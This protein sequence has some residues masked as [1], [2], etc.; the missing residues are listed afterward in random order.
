MPD[1]TSVWTPLFH[2]AEGWPLALCDGSTV[3]NQGF[4]TIRKIR[5]GFEGDGV[6]PLYRRHYKWY[7]LE[8]RAS[9]EGKN[10]DSSYSVKAKCI[11]FRIARMEP[12]NY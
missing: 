4:I 7:Y 3:T 2:P 11:L 5:H 10:Y 1:C 6:C 9:N 8:A 12:C